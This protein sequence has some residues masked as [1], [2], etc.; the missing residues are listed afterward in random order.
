MK[1][2]LKYIISVLILSITTSCSDFLN[3]SP[4]KTG[5]ASIYHMDQLVQLMGNPGIY[6]GYGYLW[7]ELLLASDECDITPY[8]YKKGVLQASAYKICHLDRSFY[9]NGGL[10]SLSWRSSLESMFVFNTVLESLDK[11]EQTTLQDREMVKG[12]ALFGRAYFHFMSMVAFCKMDKSAPGLG[13][14]DNTT[15][16][17]IPARQTVEYTLGR[18]MGDIGEAETALKAAGKTLF[19]PKETFRI[20]LPTLY[21]LKARVL[22]YFGKYPEALE[23]A[24]LALAGNSTLVDFTK[25]PAYERKNLSQVKLL[26]AAGTTVSTI[27]Y[28]EMP[29]LLGLGREGVAKDPELFLPSTCN[30]YFTARAVPISESLYNLFDRDHDNRWIYF[31]QNNHNVAKSTFSKGLTP[32]DQNNIKPWEYFSYLRYVGSSSSSGKLYIIGMSVGEMM[33]I[34]A[35]CLARAGKT[36]EAQ[37]V[38]RA[39]R[40]V[41]FNDAASANNI[42]GSLADVLSERR[43]ELTSVFRWYD[44]KRLNYN[45]NANIVITKTRCQGFDFNNPV[46]TYSLPANDPFYAIPIPGSEA[47]LMGWENN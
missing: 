19:N 43:R 41:R 13:Y 38:L 1:K 27:P 25:D 39:L 4:N 6:N 22:L 34:K 5:N 21:A 23:A 16:N 20:T 37:A 32:E 33:L 26:D 36:A 10:N 30:M 47:T 12:Q 18:I 40:T 29:N 35:E 11:V 9:L 46:E 8:F 45:D 2:S 28:Y 7:Q 14:R 42:G 44:I 15:P 31:Y 3:V 17:D 24:N